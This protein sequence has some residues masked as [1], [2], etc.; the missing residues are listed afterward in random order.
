MAYKSGHPDYP[1]IRI[2]KRPWPPAKD[3]PEDKLKTPNC[4]IRSGTS[5][6]I[7]EDIAAE[8]NNLPDVLPTNQLDG[9][10]KDKQRDTTGPETAL[11]WKFLKRQNGGDDCLA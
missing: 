6:P 10:K 9:H 2:S 1:L 8:E 7:V 5:E 11:I 3:Q 4:V